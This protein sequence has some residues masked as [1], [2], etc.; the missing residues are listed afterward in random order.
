MSLDPGSR[1][2]PYE[3]IAGVGAGG[4][5]EVYRARDTRLD[6]TVA[7]KV[8]QGHLTENPEVRARFER[9]A[10]SVSSL[11][12]PNICT[13][14]DVGNENGVDF[15]VMEFLEGESL[16]ARLERG[17]L[18]TEELLRVAIQV[19]DALDKAHRQGV[20]HR[21]LKPGNVMLTK[22]GA[23]LLDFGLAR[24][25]GLAPGS[26]VH[27]HSPTMSRPLTA[28]G[29]IVGTFQ[30][31][32]PEQLEGEEAD[33]RTDLFAFGA[34]LYEMATG[35]RAFEG[36]SQA[37]VIAAI[38]ERQPPSISTLQPLAPP[39]LERVI[40]TC[41][42]K[43]REQRRQSAH[44]VLLELRWIQQGG[45]QASAPAAA[46]LKRRGQSRL[47]WTVAGVAAALLAAHVAYSF[48]HRPPPADVVRL[49]V[50]LP[51]GITVTDSPRMSPDGRTLAFNGGDSTGTVR[52]W[53]RPISSFVAQPLPGTEGAAR[54]FWSPDSRYIGFFADGK[55]KKI[56]VAGGP[57]QAI[58][59]SGSRGDGSWGRAGV[60]L[61]DGGTTDSI[62]RVSASGGIPGPATVIERAKGET[63]HA[64]PWFLPD[65]K[66]FLFLTLGNKPEE[67]SVKIGSIDSKE[68][69]VLA[70]GAYSRVEYANGYMLW[71]RDRSVMAQRFDAGAR[72]LVGEPFP[73]ADEVSGDDVGAGNANFSASQNGALAT[74]RGGGAESAKLVWVDRTGR[75]EEETGL[76]GEYRGISP[77]PDGT[78][79][80]VQT[81]SADSDIWLLD[82][83]RKASTR[84]T[85]HQ[86]L[87][88][89]PVWSPDGTKVAFSSN[90]DGIFGVFVKPADGVGAETKLFG[91][92][93]NTA[94]V[95]WSSDGRYILLLR[96]GGST[97]WDLVA[98]P[99][100]GDSTMIPVAT[101]PFV[102]L[103]GRFSPDGRW[104]VYS[105]NESGRREVYV[106]PFPTPAGKW[107]ISTAGGR[108]PIFSADGKE[109]YFI[110]PGGAMMAVPLE[111]GAGIRPG[112]P[113]QLFNGA[114]SDAIQFGHSFA[115][116]PDG[117]RFLMRR[118]RGAR[119]LLPTNITLNWTSEVGKR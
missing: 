24:N 28:E 91:I 33:A 62:M 39:A 22:G 42:A 68:S 67:A 13:L 81:T 117:K 71:A 94:P 23:K 27:S 3:I 82:L 72:K 86:A 44:D 12:H 96:V 70:T 78:R 89:W 102:E 18:P 85:F 8:L 26:G 73:I 103:E 31:M 60:I 109:I 41:L 90:R 65:G 87:D 30:Y 97:R 99:A 29:T 20:I 35:K 88:I 112:V 17:P 77:S 2:G 57:P 74:R 34:M 110:S 19:A 66:H 55:L 83:A 9:E 113:Q 108:D 59:E 49:Q 95:D 43:D 115:V 38:L 56:A 92:A 105:S 54:P 119:T 111:I 48:L 114:Q 50:P 84:F 106:Q 69:K 100:N 118:S 6:R 93:E 63:G 10:R 64:W 58:C 80:A 40:E 107:Q 14:Y 46:A 98:I 25:T 51:G 21:D 47:A 16:A 76:E 5:G 104:V 1:L 11:N 37:S 32:A 45:S 53:L 52:I 7:I 75:N 61:F 4:M 36:K 101:T 79:V 116:S 15:I